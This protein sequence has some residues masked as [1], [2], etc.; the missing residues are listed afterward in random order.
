MRDPSPARVAATAKRVERASGELATRAQQLMQQTLPWFAAMPAEPRAQV[1]LLLQ[2]GIRGLGRWLVAPDDGP[3]IT[4]EVFAT[5]PRD[6]AR[7]VSLEHTVELVRLAVRVAEE[8]VGELAAPDQQAWLREATLRYSR[9]IAFAAA[10]VYARAA[11]QRGRWDARLESL[12]VDAVARG[13]VS[14][15]LLSRASALGWSQPARVMVMAGAAPDG[16]SERVLTH[17]RRLG[18]D[19]GADVLAGISSGRLVVIVGFAGR[20][21][22]IARALLPAF[23]AGPVVTGPPI[24][25]LAEAATAVQDVFAGLRAATA[26]P[27]APRPVASDALL[28]ERA[29]AGDARA[30]RSLVAGVYDRLAEDP[31]LLATADAYLDCS[32]GIEATA[33]EMFVHPNTVRYRLKRIS[34]ICDI[35][36]AVGRDRY[37]AQ[38]AI[39]LGRLESSRTGL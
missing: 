25:G 32:G 2:A 23:A 27:G 15:S 36:L 20:L 11:E 38:V 39:A 13:D 24:T 6:L 33:R 7:L 12:V 28:P 5:A 19:A 22:R 9:E 1:G 10:L 31:V 29:L 16:D 8:A 17:A 26:W 34:D 3:Q 18:Q 35:D 30:T 21:A 14:D 4:A 37:A